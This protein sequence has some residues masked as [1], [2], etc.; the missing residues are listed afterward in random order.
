M[1]V[2]LHFCLESTDT[3]SRG[4]HFPQLLL[5]FAF[6]CTQLSTLPRQFTNRGFQLGDIFGRRGG[7]HLL[8]AEEL[9]DFKCIHFGLLQARCSLDPGIRLASHPRLRDLERLLGVG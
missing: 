7:L 3:V 4:T 5:Q 9:L 2:S 8:P 1:E 6:P